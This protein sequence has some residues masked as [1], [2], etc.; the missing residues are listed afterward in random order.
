MVLEK[1]LHLASL[2]LGTPHTRLNECGHQ[3]RVLF[4]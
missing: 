2:V 4:C 3:T 1:R